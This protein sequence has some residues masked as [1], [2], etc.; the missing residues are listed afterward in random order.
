MKAPDE[1]SKKTT[2]SEE[3]LAVRCVN[4]WLR[5]TVFS[6]RAYRKMSKGMG[7]DI[8]TR[9]A[10]NLDKLRNKVGIKSDEEQRVFNFTLDLLRNFSRKKQIFLT[11]GGNHEKIRGSGFFLSYDELS[12]RNIQS[13]SST[14][15][16]DHEFGN[17]DFVFFRIQFG[18]RHMAWRLKHTDRF[19]NIGLNSCM[20]LKT[21]KLPSKAFFTHKDWYDLAGFDGYKE[22]CLNISF[23]GQDNILEAIAW[24]FLDVYRNRS[25]DKKRA[26]LRASMEDYV[27]EHKEFVSY[28]NL[29]LDKAEL[30][31]PNQVCLADFENYKSPSIK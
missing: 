24:N 2:K 26:S 30:K 4:K 1:K 23:Y 8:R 17:T 13:N 6:N 10:S 9:T 20:I 12:R 28:L 11:H 25:D 22:L 21:D 7:D 5:Q 16:I 27:D 18:L 31:V 19:S 3:E 14:Y 29:V 15:S